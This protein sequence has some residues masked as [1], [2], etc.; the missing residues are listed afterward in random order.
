MIREHTQKKRWPRYG[1]DIGR[2]QNEFSK[3]VCI[4]TI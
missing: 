4:R 3:F 2:M 1:A